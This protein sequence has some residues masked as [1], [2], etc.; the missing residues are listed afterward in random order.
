MENLTLKTKYSSFTGSSPYERFLE[1]RNGSGA[2]PAAAQRTTSYYSMKRADI[3]KPKGKLVKGSLIP[4]PFTELYQG[5]KNFLKA[6][7]GEG[8]D[9]SVGRINDPAIAVGAGAIATVL[10]A[11]QKSTRLKAMEFIGAGV[12]LTA[13]AVWPKL[14]L[15]K[16]VKAMTGVDLNLDYINSQGERKPFFMDSQYIPWDLMD[17]ER[18]E[19]AG[20]KLNVPEGIENRDE[21][22]QRRMRKVSTGVNTW[23]MLSAGFSTPLLAS[24]LANMLEKPVEGLVNKAKLISAQA[25]LEAAGIN[26]GSDNLFVRMGTALVKMFDKGKDKLFEREG[27]TLEALLKKGD[28]KEIHEFFKSLTDS[29]QVRKYLLPEVD[30]TLGKTGE[31]TDEAKAAVKGIFNEFKQLNI[32]E[33]AFG[34]YTAAVDNVWGTSRR[35]IIEGFVEKLGIKGKDLKRLAEST[36]NVDSNAGILQEAVQRASRDGKTAKVAGDMEDLMKK[37]VAQIE[38]FFSAVPRYAEQI[39]ERVKEGPLGKVARSILN[40]A[41]DNAGDK[42]VGVRA[43]VSGIPNIVRQG[44]DDIE[45]IRGITGQKLWNKLSFMEPDNRK[46]LLNKIF[47]KENPVVRAITDF[48]L[49]STDGREKIAQRMHV[50]LGENPADM[51]SRAAESLQGR[52]GWLK[53]VGLAFTAVVGLSALALWMITKNAKKNEQNKKVEA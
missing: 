19:E 2:L 38:E 46:G 36:G 52:T 51:F 30:K 20:R 33:R 3:N 49:E 11:S 43:S 18:L 8:T 26:T 1:I 47:G 53:K 10:A 39:L 4:N 23:W 28:R 22:I 42:A 17:K 13:M 12:F 50:K 15:A 35:N 32:L 34:K 25:H 40:P 16:P 7:K 37:P 45:I 14:F 41:M 31:I 24:L 6:T 21:E 9:Y 5:A 27:K 44:G 48:L 29:K